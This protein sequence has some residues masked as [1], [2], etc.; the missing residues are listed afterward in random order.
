MN[1]KYANS[2]SKPTKQYIYMKSYILT[3][4]ITDWQVKGS[5]ALRNNS[6]HCGLNK[7]FS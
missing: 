7:N 1:T 4:F 5:I 3:S 6:F 2:L